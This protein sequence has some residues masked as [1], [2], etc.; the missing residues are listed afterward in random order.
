[1]ITDS[2]SHNSDHNSL[3]TLDTSHSDTDHSI[4]PADSPMI[5]P[6]SMELP[7]ANDPTNTIPDISRHINVH[8]MTYY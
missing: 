8:P 3:E 1:M 7:N 6:E 5:Y 4:N 2:S